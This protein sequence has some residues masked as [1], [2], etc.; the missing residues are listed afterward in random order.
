M[1]TLWMYLFIIIGGSMRIVGPMN[2]Q[3]RVTEWQTSLN[4]IL[5][6]QNRPIF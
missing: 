2:A 1:S 4:R 5:L 3:H 6:N